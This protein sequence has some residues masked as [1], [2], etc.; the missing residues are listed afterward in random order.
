MSGVAAAADLHSAGAWL[1]PAIAATAVVIVVAGFV[2]LRP[3][4]GSGSPLESP[5]QGGDTTAL[6]PGSPTGVDQCA[7]RLTDED[8]VTAFAA[9][10]EL[11][12]IAQRDRASS[13]AVIA[14]WCEHLRAAP[15]G[16]DERVARAVQQRLCAHLKRVARRRQRRSTL[17]VDLSDTQLHDLDLDGIVVGGLSVARAR[18][19]GTTRLALRSW[20]GLDA[21][22]AYFGGDLL[23]AD[24]GVEGQL[25]LRGALIEGVLDLQGAAVFGELDMSGS[26][27]AQ[28]T[29]LRDLVGGGLRLQSTG[30]A[31]LFAG[32][33]DLS[34]TIADPVDLAGDEFTGGL[35]IKPPGAERSTVL[36][37]DE[38]DLAEQVREA[39]EAPL[40]V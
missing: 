13:A 40:R 14:V 30:G 2:A 25:S 38:E 16:R 7:A 24:V 28:R 32:A 33:V 19:A 6:N 5:A 21:S 39:L 17:H 9:L 26:E 31:A 35:T 18:L 10:D 8:L 22:E 4:V 1:F 29:N 12:A 23:A 20:G 3:R 37:G 34:R 36:F 15:I 27:V 11:S